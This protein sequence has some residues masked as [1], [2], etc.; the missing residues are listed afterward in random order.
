MMSS[1]EKNSGPRYSLRSG[2]FIT[3]VWG[4]T[5]GKSLRLR[6]GFGNLMLSHRRGLLSTM[7]HILVHLAR[8]DQLLITW[9]LWSPLLT[10]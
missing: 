2:K 8:V 9:L 6:V 10:A 1:L 3:Q 7:V 4:T 5:I